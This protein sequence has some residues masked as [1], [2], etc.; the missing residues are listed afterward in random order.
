MAK[1]KDEARSD[2]LPCRTANAKRGAGR[3]STVGSQASKAPCQRTCRTDLQEHRGLSRTVP[4]GSR[5]RSV[6]VERTRPKLSTAFA[7]VR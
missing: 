5:H 3:A 6:L 4:L 2:R 7:S 1:D